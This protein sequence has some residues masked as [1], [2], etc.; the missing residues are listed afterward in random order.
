MNYKKLITY[1]V[2]SFLL[3]ACNTLKFKVPDTREV[4]II[5]NDSTIKV[6]IPSEEIKIKTKKKRIY[7][8][9]KANKIHHNENGYEGKIL[10]GYYKILLNNGNLVGK[11][12]FRK[13]LKNGIWEEW[14][15]NGNLKNTWKWKNG[16]KQGEYK[17]YDHDGNLTEAGHFKKN[18]LTGKILYYRADSVYKTQKYK[19]GVL[20]VKKASSKAKQEKQGS[21][22]SNK[23]KHTFWQNLF[24]KNKKS[25]EKNQS[26]HQTDKKNKAPFFKRIFKSK[27]HNKSKD[28]K[29]R[30]D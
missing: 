24:K 14:Y 7:W 29:S 12:Y 10:N 3:Y 6:Q 21:A 2:L 20:I 27:K 23:I 28:N 5:K 16:V 9:Y 8:W 13:G 26:K 17:R 15:A 25:N 11:G 18:L 1:T 4:I 19:K 30:N 22:E